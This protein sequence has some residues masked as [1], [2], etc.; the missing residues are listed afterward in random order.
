[1]KQ[2]YLKYGLFALLPTLFMA[3]SN[4]D[5]LTPD[6][7][8]DV[9]ARHLVFSS[10]DVGAD[11]R[12]S[13]KDPNGSGKL[14]FQWDYTAEE[15]TPDEMVFAIYNPTAKESDGKSPEVAVGFIPNAKKDKWHT[16]ASVNEH[17]DSRKDSHYAEFETVEQ[18]TNTDTQLEENILFAVT[19]LNVSENHTL[20]ST[21]AGFKVELKMPNTFT[22]TKS[23]DPSF[24][25]DYMYMYGTSTIENGNASIRFYHIPATF[26]FVINNMTSE[27]INVSSVEVKADNVF[28]QSV[29]VIA[30]TTDKMFDLS[31]PTGT[32]NSITTNLDDASVDANGTFIAY[33]LALPTEE[34]INTLTFKLTIGEDSYEAKVVTDKI[35]QSGYSYTV[36]LDYYGYLTVSSVTVNGW[37]DNWTENGGIAEEKTDEEETLD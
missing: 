34:K 8:T 10:G 15:E 25:R 13:W 19:P 12:A 2:N 14:T 23:G 22:Q 20:T 5:E 3:C 28:T 33:A 21:A 24:L 37:E 4:E 36:T 29:S 7:P 11:T 30:N 35:L 16:Y 31:F 9:V 1:M 32:N 26:R 27:Q 6:T 18:Y 17:S